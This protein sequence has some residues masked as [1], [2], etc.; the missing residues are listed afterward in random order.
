MKKVQPITLANFFKF[1]KFLRNPPIPH[2]QDTSSLLFLNMKIDAMA[3][4]QVQ[5][6]V[7]VVAYS[8][9]SPA[10]VFTIPLEECQKYW[11]Q[12]LSRLKMYLLDDYGK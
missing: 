4:L 1:H 8:D 2:V 3:K 10:D 5:G 12:W 7:V 9:G 6:G 11:K